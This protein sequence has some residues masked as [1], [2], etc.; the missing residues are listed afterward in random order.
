[1][2]PIPEP[3]H[4][5]AAGIG[6]TEQIRSATAEKG[7]KVLNR[8]VERYLDLIRDLEENY[9]PQEVPGSDVKQR[10][11]VKRFAVNY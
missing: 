4:R 6:T 7:E 3:G 10:P 5:S 1:M 2:I 9:A 11:A 8:A